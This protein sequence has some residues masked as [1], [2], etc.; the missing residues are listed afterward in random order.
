MT[1]WNISSVSFCGRASTGGGGSNVAVT[2]GQRSSLS[3]LVVVS[4]V[5]D[6]QDRLAVPALQFSKAVVLAGKTAG[7]GILTGL[8]MLA[9]LEQQ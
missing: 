2:V 8:A 7:M 3:N 1:L 9:P 6:H 4:L 5:G